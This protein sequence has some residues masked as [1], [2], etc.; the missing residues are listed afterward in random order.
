MIHADASLVQHLRQLLDAQIVAAGEIVD[1]LRDLV[2]AHD[3]ADPCRFLHLDRFVDE[4][5]AGFF[6]QIA[7]LTLQPE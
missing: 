1:R 2:I 4:L 6:I 5:L 3:T 7:R